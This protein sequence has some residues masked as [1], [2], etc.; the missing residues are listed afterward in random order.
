MIEQSH[1]IETPVLHLAVQ[2]DDSD[3]EGGQTDD[4]REHCSILTLHDVSGWN[5]LHTLCEASADPQMIQILLESG[6]Q[7]ST[8]GDEFS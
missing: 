4:Y 7:T 6:R 8:I 5:A 1:T 2:D 3:S